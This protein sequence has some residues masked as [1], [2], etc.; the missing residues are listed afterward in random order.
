[1]KKLNSDFD[2]KEENPSDSS[3]KFIPVSYDNVYEDD[4]EDDDEGDG[5][6]CHYD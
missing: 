5:F 6:D 4:D 3:F 1:M 2:V